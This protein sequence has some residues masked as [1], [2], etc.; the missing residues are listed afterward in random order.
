LMVNQVVTIT[1]NPLPT[2]TYELSDTEVCSGEEVTYTN[3]FSGTPPWTVEFMYNGVL[4]S[5]I[6]SDNPQYYTD[7]FTETAIYEPVSVTD[8]NGCTS[9][10]DQPATITVHPL[11]TYTYELSETEVCSG[12]EVTYTN[13]FTGTPP[14]T[15]EFLYNGVLTSF[16]T[17]DNPQ[18][19]TEVLTTNTT[20]EPLS[21][22]DGNGCS[23]E[24][25]QPTIF[26]VNPLPTFGYELSDTEVCFGEEVLITNHFTGIAPWTVEYTYNG[27]FSTFTTSENPEY[28]T[29]AFDETTIYEPLK[30]TDGNGCSATVNQISTI[31]VH[32]LPQLSCP[33]FMEAIVNEPPVLL[34]SVTP[35]GGMYT[36]IGVI[37]NGTDYFFDP[38][39]G[40]GKWQIT[41]CYSDPTNGCGNCCDFNFIVKP[42]PGDEQ[43]ICIPQ[44]WSAISSYY[45]PDNPLMPDVFADLNIDNKVSIVLGENGLYWPSQNINTIGNWDVKKGYKIKMNQAACLEIEGE[46]PENRIIT[47]KKGISYIPVL[48]T[49]PVPATD[50]FDQFGTNLKFAFDIYSGQIFWPAGGLY[51]LQYLEPGVGYLVSLSAQSQA[52]YE[53]SKSLPENYVKASPKSYH[54]APWN[55]DNTGVP[56]FVSVNGSAFAGI[57]PGDYLGVFNAQGVCTGYTQFESETE[58]LLLVA[59]GDDFTTETIDGLGEGEAMIFRIYHNATMTEVTL[60]V[61]YDASMPNA[62]IFAELGQSAITYVSEGAALFV[63]NK[64]SLINLY[65]NPGKGLFNVTIP[66]MHESLIIEVTAPSG[67][68]ILT[69]IIGISETGQI[70]KLD[71]TKVNPGVYFVRIT[72]GNL[73][74]TKKVVIE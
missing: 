61:N 2:Y 58:T 54:N 14:W 37:F 17:S 11:P 28:F 38:S 33:P 73:V 32:P 65:P 4:D 24:V 19:Y 31:V 51:T 59:Y 25:N 74:T 47:P 6:T 16:T 45:T 26:T 20:F 43:V 21:V 48:C 46:F 66:E 27:I 1:V 22:T 55:F 42:I 57:T 5:F 70:H 49:N 7:V 15:V 36:G 60:T 8:G 29:Y 68:V 50:I 69:K 56:H 44:G 53:C 30:V 10:I 41:Y 23:S 3:H 64:L 62:G 13:H 9:T 35:E 39:I 34:N 12:E 40:V 71:L 63:E 52:M 67:Q 72:S 18:I